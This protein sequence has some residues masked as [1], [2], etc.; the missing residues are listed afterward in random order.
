MSEKVPS[1]MTSRKYYLSGLRGYPA[2]DAP[3][4]GGYLRIINL[5]LK[6]FD[7]YPGRELVQL[8]GVLEC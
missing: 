7:G 8:E 6:A 5:S 2:G 3:S 1:M 4:I